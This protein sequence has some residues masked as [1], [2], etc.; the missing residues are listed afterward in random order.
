MTDNNGNGTK[1]WQRTY[2]KV[3]VVAL[4]IS[5]LVASCT[6]TD[7]YLVANQSEFD[8]LRYEFDSYSTTSNG[9]KKEIIRRLENIEQNQIH[10]MIELGIQP[11]RPKGEPKND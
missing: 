5:I 7:K 6:A 1:F 11:P 4:S 10:L 9:D 3:A 8:E 2:F